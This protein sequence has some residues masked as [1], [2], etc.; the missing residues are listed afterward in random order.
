MAGVLA[1]LTGAWLTMY[2]KLW[3]FERYD[4][5]RMTSRAMLTGTLRL[6]AL[7]SHAG[8]D[9][10][11]Y[12]GA[13]YTNWGFG[14]PILQM[15]FHAIA[16]ISTS[17]HGFFPDRAIYF[18]YVALLA[19]V[20]WAAFDRLLAERGDTR[21]LR[22]LLVSWAATWLALNIVLFPFMSTRF[23]VFEQTVA[24]M[25]VCELFALAAY[26][27]AVPRW[28][29]GPVV[30]MAVAAGMGLLVRPIGLLY[31]GVW[32]ALVILEGRWRKAVLYLGSLA[33]FAAFWLYSNWVRSGSVVGLGY[34]NSNPAW[35][36]EMPVLRFGATCGNTPWHLLHAAGR[37]FVGFFFYIWPTATDP[38]LRQ[39]H[40][41]FEERDGTREPY[42]GPWVLVLLV[43]LAVRMARRRERRID[44]AVPYAAL[45][46][47]FATFVRRGEGFAWRYVGD[48][49][50]LLVL[51]VVKEVRACTAE[52]LAPLDLRLA[53]VFFWAGLVNL[54]RLL[55]PW[56]WNDRAEIV[57]VSETAAM[58]RR[59]LV[60]RWGKDDPMPS[61]LACD[62]RGTI[63][64]T[65]FD[66]GMGWRQGCAVGAVTNVYLGVRPKP[67]SQYT[68][69][70]ETRGMS[71]PRLRLYANGSVYTARR[72]GDAY[73]AD[74]AIRSAAL[75]SPVVVVTIEWAAAGATA[76]GELLSVELT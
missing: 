18:A 16:R 4:A 31:A 76:P 41:D 59:F 23:V 35:E 9:E 62:G 48:F 56:Q 8:H 57:P 47:L 49:W 50:P 14:V 34:A 74:V 20:L 39:C 6:R 2:G 22:R 53:H 60:D 26:V 1:L 71:A 37:L 64:S 15:P 72:D 3:C 67:G 7:V 11:V 42:F 45:A 10:E 55:V 70:F 12:N 24:Y 75:V 28:G 54:V 40:F 27:F 43:G 58:E 61:R 63:A 5:H 46:L 17:L 30:G 19:P 73:V 65:P 66:D 29:A 52:Q 13:V 36:W 44:M 38:W 33:P 68:V 25:V 32:A 69:R 21:P 51:A